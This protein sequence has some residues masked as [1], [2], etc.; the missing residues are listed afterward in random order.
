MTIDDDLLAEAKAA[1]AWQ[2]RTLSDVVQD[3]LR[4]SLR[5][6]DAT[7]PSVVLPTSGHPTQGPLVDLLDKEALAEV[8]GDNEPPF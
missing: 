7:A 4:M 6:P 3:A 8:L 2:R 1:A 5:R